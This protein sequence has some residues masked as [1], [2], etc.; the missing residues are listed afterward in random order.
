MFLIDPVYFLFA[1]PGLILAMIAQGMVKSAYHQAQQRQSRRGIT[2]EETARAILRAAG[3]DDV[4]VEPSHGFL[5]DHYHP[6]QKKLRLSPTNFNE[7]HLGAVGIAAHEVGHAL[8]HRYG[9]APMYLRSFLVPVCSAGTVVS[10]IALIGGLFLGGTLGKTLLLVAIFAFAALTL[11][12]L[13]TL[14]VEF[15]ASRRAIRVLEEQQLVDPDEM[16]VVRKVLRAAAL[17][18]VAA[19]INAILMLLYVIMRYNSRD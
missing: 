3:I 13:V 11:F 2:G 9:Y 4:G 6:L 12:T 17:T 10:E 14:P 5:S 1:V 15:N 18:Y 19:A 8:Q 16:P 7:T